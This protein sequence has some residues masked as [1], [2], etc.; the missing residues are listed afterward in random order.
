M[1]RE[2]QPPQVRPAD[3]YG[4]RPARSGWVTAAIV[5]AGVVFTAIVAAL[6]WQLSHPALS[7]QLRGYDIISDS[8]VRVTALIRTREPNA[9]V[10]CTARARD[11]AGNE[12]GRT[13][14]RT[15]PDTKD[16]TRIDAGIT[17]RLVTVTVRTVV[18]A[19]LGE[20]VD[21]HVTR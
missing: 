17:E 19:N 2:E 3:R 8:Q 5:T 11:R 12:V 16:P 9:Q 1:D 20:V 13:A 4:D 18:R 7:D 14:L 15:G 10:E 21:C 6:G